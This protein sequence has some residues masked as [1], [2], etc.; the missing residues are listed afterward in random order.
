MTRGSP[1]RDRA[2]RLVA[3][4]LAGGLVDFVYPVGM[5]LSRG[6][7][8]E[9]PWLS[10]ASGWIGK[11]ARAG[12]PGPVA[13][14]IATHFA[15]AVC[16]AL[17][18]ALVARRLPVLYR[19]WARCGAVYGVVLYGIMYRLV[20]PLRFGGGAGGWQGTQS[21]LDICAHV[22]VGLAVAYVLARPR[23]QRS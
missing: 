16:M 10:V 15:I 7:S 6:K 14:G 20:L 23:A 21:W 8:W 5:A 17:A 13:L 11:A 3:A 18:Y 22:G 9:S 2:I 1:I 19:R 12:G 4:G